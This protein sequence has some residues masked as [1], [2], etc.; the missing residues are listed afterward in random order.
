MKLVPFRIV[1]CSAN[2]P[3]HGPP[4]TVRS[5]TVRPAAGR[6][7]A[8][9]GKIITVVVLDVAGAHAQIASGAASVPVFERESRM[10]LSCFAVTAMAASLFA[11]APVFAQIRSDADKQPAQSLSHSDA[12][13]QPAQSY[14]HSNTGIA[15]GVSKKH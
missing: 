6:Q 15:D 4:V 3:V 12:T 11:A 14:S 13:K 2:L 10:K 1:V 5:V 8:G 7:R 9:L